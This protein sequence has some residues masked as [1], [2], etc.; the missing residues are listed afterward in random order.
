MHR[1]WRQSLFNLTGL[2]LLVVGLTAAAL[3]LVLPTLE[4]R[5]ERAR[6]MLLVAVSAYV[7]TVAIQRWPPRQPGELRQIR[8]LR[9]ALV[10]HLGRQQRL[11]G[12]ALSPVGL[13]FQDTLRAVD[14]L[15]PALADLLAR[16]QS[17]IEML[18]RFR[19]GA[20]SAPDEAELRKLE[21]AVD[22]QQEAIVAAVRQVANACAALLTIAYEDSTSARVVG[23]IE[24]W[25][26]K[27]REIRGTLALLLDESSHWE[28]RLAAEEQRRGR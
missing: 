8:H 3:T 20:L 21:T 22:G 9:A 5:A 2:G 26:D 19:S 15:T 23:D 4:H 11:P 12:G 25:S 27:L 28:Q 17:L 14:D 18:D 16:Q 6:A 10:E 1:T 7:A 24:R 13:L